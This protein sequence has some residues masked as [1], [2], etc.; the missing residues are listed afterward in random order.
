MKKIYLLL[1]VS[2]ILA[3]CSGDDSSDNPG[4]GNDVST[5][6][7]LPL[8]D[9]NYWVYDVE[10]SQQQGSDY[11]YITGDMVSNGHTYKKFTT[12]NLPFGLFTS[13]VY[14]NGI[15]KE[16]DKLLL[17]GNA[18]FG[19][20]E[21][22]SLDIPI[23]DFVVLKENASAN[24]QLGT[25]SGSITQQ[26]EGYDLKFDYTLSTTNKQDHASYTV[27][28][29]T[30]TNVK[31]VETTLNLKVTALANIPNVGIV[32]VQVMTPQ[33]VVVSNQYYADGIGVVFVTSDINYTLQ[34]FSLISITLPIPQ[35][36]SE[37]QEETL[38]TYSVE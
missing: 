1:S 35:S 21:E 14:N 9:G 12:Q 7:F 13:A 25:T 27:G 11:L 24:Q 20:S 29:Q 33:N 28:L 26:Y 18:E 22:F 32:P 2:I 34:D 17:S 16:G 15:R 5:A 23:T 4:N 38:D 6:D 3:S 31:Q 8:A 30:Y 36:A 19:F 10:N 37:H